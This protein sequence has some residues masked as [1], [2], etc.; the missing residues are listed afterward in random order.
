M[1]KKKDIVEHVAATTPLKKFQAREALEAALGFMREKIEA[2]EDVQ[3]PPLGKVR[4]IVQ[5]EG[6]PKE[7]VVFRLVPTKRTDKGEADEDG[8]SED[9]GSHEDAAEETES[10]AS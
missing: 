5:N 1:I 3:I 9:D 7:K 8:T 10:T 2:G 6:T 4:V